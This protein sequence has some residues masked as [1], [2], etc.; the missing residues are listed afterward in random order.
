MLLGTMLGLGALYYFSVFLA[1][2]V[3]L[4]QHMIVTPTDFHR[5]T[6]AYF[7]RNSLVPLVMLVCTWLDFVMRA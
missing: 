2:C 3:L 6:Q 5:V 1:G 4:Y 7:M